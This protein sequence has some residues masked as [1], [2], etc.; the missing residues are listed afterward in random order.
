[1]IT[2]FDL[3]P[4]DDARKEIAN[5]L[6]HIDRFL[7]SRENGVSHASK[8][9]LQAYLKSMFASSCELLTYVVHKDRYELELE[10]GF[11]NIKAQLKRY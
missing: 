4:A 1:M 5:A 2:D 7:N 10:M 9:D 8:A 6:T 11:V 3:A